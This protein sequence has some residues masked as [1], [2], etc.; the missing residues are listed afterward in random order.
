MNSREKQGRGFLVSF[1]FL[2]NAFARSLACF[3]LETHPCFLSLLGCVSDFG[4]LE[5]CFHLPPTAVSVG[6]HCNWLCQLRAM[7]F[8]VF[9]G[10][11]GGQK[12]C[13]EGADWRGAK[14]ALLQLTPSQAQLNVRTERTTP[15][16]L[17]LCFQESHY[18]FSAGLHF[19]LLQFS[20]LSIARRCRNG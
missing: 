13:G 3:N 9:H 2:S 12:L 17:T 20:V 19:Q 1:I 14:R 18:V 4:C 10:T 5:C 15:R 7:G 6:P 11:T 8:S 16:V